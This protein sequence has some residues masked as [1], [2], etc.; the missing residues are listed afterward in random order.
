M[1]TTKSVRSPKRIHDPKRR[2]RLRAILHQMWTE[3]AIANLARAELQRRG[4]IP[5]TA[6]VRR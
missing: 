1:K 4:R 3:E 2:R 5:T 6:A